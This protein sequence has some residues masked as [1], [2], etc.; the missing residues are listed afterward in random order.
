[1]KVPETHRILKGRLG[2]DASFGNNGAF[3]IP[4]S[5]RT[6]AFVIASDGG[7]W[8]HVSVSILSDNIERTPTWSEMCRIKDM[9][10]EEEETVIQFHPPKSQYVNNHKHCLHLWKP[11]EIEIPLPNP[12]MVGIN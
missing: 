4:L 10:W 9:F 7:G 5:G 2:S 1:M 8:Q 12:L 11:I 3:E 6:K